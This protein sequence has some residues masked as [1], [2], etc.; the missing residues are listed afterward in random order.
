MYHPPPA[1][2]SLFHLKASTFLFQYML[3]I[4]QRLFSLCHFNCSVQQCECNNWSGNNKSIVQQIRP[5]FQLTPPDPKGRCQA[6]SIAIHCKPVRSKAGRVGLIPFSI[7]SQLSSAFSPHNW[8]I[9]GPQQPLQVFHIQYSWNHCIGFCCN[10]WCVGFCSSQLYLSSQIYLF[11][12]C[13]SSLA[14]WKCYRQHESL[15]QR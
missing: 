3:D 11:I 6:E 7:L 2:L 15:I 14:T 8:S 4:H 12:W 10:S 9:H 13:D 5:F 1:R